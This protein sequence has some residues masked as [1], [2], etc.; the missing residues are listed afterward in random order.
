MKK[1]ID[2]FVKVLLVT[3]LC[4]VMQSCFNLDEEWYS[5]VTPDT[6]FKTKENIYSVASRPFTHGFW[7]EGID[8]WYLQE[9]TADQMIQPQRGQDWYDGGIF[10]RLQYH[11]WTPDDAHIWSTWRG[12]GMGISLALECKKDLENLN[13]EDFG[14][15]EDEKQDLYRQ[16][17]EE[18]NQIHERIQA[19][20]RGA[21]PQ[22][23][24]TQ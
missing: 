10:F 23:A 21:G 7:Y 19:Y 5:E 18:V 14:L 12:T 13:Y 20:E 1:Y 8:R 2:K 24:Q 17:R 9:Y 3:A 11:K 16:C 15:T 22:E 6:F 4:P